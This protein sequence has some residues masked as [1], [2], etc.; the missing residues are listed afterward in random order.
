V[1]HKGIEARITG[2]DCAF[3]RRAFGKFL[4]KVVRDMEIERVRALT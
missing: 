2:K 4:P 1:P 3:E